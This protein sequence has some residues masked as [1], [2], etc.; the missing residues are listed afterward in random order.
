MPELPEV[1]V[2]ARGLDT[3]VAGRTIESVEVPG[4]TRL[5]EPE[6]T[7]VPKVLGRT[8]IRV[9]R[10]AKVLLMELDTGST[11][12]FHLKMTGRVVHGPN[13]TAEKHDRI[14]FHLDDGSLLSFA[15]MRKFG[16]VRCFAPGELDCWDFLC[17]AGPEPL[18]TAPEVLAERVT[19][20]NC[21]IKALLLNQSVVAGVGNIYADES[22]FRAG[23]NPETRGSRVGRDKAVK[24][25]TELQAVLKQAIAENGSSISDYVNA[26]GDAGAF[27]NSFNVYGRKGQACKQC[28]DTLRAVTVAGRTSTFCPKCQ[29][30]R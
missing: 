6:E 26:H 22:L 1:E 19:G 16:Y 17:K 2:I 20:R 23:I 30:R 28:G 27:Q 14:L 29:R 25:F 5:S 21:A 9:W 12:A 24:L 10:R 18:E 7:L 11:M 13:R 4:L 8:I 3:S 15:D